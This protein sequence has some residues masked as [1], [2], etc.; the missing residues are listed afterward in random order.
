MNPIC[1]V[2]RSAQ[3][4]LR[5]RWVLLI[6]NGT[7]LHLP[8]GTSHLCLCQWLCPKAIPKKYSSDLGREWGLIQLSSAV[9]HQDANAN[10]P[11]PFPVSD[12]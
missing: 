10:H 2:A 9:G 8:G 1:S 4:A 3:T 6:T 11:P 12:T 5:K 7:A